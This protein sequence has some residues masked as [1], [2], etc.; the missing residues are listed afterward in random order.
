MRQTLIYGIIAL[1]IVIIVAAIAFFFSDPDRNTNGGD[2]DQDSGF[3]GTLF[4]F[5][6]GGGAGDS[7]LLDDDTP[8]TDGEQ[9][10]PR[11]RQ[12]SASPV[13][14]GFM[15]EKD[16]VTM[17]RF[18]DR[19]TGHVYETEAESTTVT[20]LTN[21]TVPGIQE[22]LWVNENEFIIRYLD[23]KTIETFYVSLDAEAI[24]EQPLNGT[25]IDS[26]D[27][28]ALD[29][30]RESLFAVFENSSGSDLIISDPNG[31]SARTVLA[32]SV[33]SWVPLQ[34]S[35]GLFVQTAPAAEGA[36][37]LYQIIN[38]ALTRVVGPI[39][40]LA[41]KISDEGDYVLV[42][43]TQQARA[44]T[45]ALFDVTK[46]ELVATVVDT[47][48]EKCVFESE[49]ATR[50]YCGVPAVFP[51]GEYPDDWFLG[52]VSFDDSI[53]LVEPADGVGTR[54]ASGE[55]VG[56]IFDV[57]QPMLSPNGN[58]FLFINKNDL[59]LW[60]LRIPEEG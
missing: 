22:V 59:S 58:Y 9:E 33:R 16:E 54:I 12:V 52:R 60:S 2:T 5:G 47:F 45:L 23:N 21:T 36:G 11:L 7:P 4:P 34:S 41:S 26:F 53:W 32:S 6:N 10:A 28:A 46:G 40:G 30:S 42:S 44:T 55:D 8:L 20:R 29:G 38:G 49:D 18:V 27:R 31:G 25:F 17:I 56:Q 13:S 1:I 3:F 43:G 50:V 35:T 57:W 39:P 48:A 15:F 19:A 37:F 51:D 24:G 14:G